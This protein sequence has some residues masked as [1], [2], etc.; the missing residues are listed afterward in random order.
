MLRMLMA[1]FLISFIVNHAEASNAINLNCNL[2]RSVLIS[3]FNYQLSTMKWNG[4]FEVASGRIRSQTQS[5][6]P[7]EVTQFSNGDD[8][9][10]Y[11]R[12]NQYMFLYVGKPPADK[13]RIMGQF[14]YSITTLPY[15]KDRPLP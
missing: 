5:G 10:Y 9:V 12:T 1:I 4:N 11:P 6:T 3:H 13:C 2:R 14:T 15:H 8:L 7:F